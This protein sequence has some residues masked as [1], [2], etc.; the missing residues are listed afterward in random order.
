M[1]PNDETNVFRKEY[2]ELTE[3]EKNLMG[4]VK[5]KA[6][7]LYDSIQKIADSREKSLAKTH[8]EESVMWAV[9]KITG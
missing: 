9:K 7:S 4:E 1:T 3:E 2:R 8:L 6:Q 5:D